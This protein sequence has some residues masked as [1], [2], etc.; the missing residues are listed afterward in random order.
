MSLGVSANQ[1]HQERFVP[2]AVAYAPRESVPCT[3]EFTR[4]RKRIECNSTD[5]LLSVA[6]RNDIDIP[7]SCRIGQCGTCATRVLTGEVEMESDEGLSPALRAEGF[8]LLCVGR[9]RGIVSLEA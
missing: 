1:I 9:A 5:T 7:A 3:V 4:S 8:S 2:G 6:E